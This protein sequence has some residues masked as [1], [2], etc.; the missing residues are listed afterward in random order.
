MT[1]GIGYLQGD[2]YRLYNRHH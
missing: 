2:T 1:K